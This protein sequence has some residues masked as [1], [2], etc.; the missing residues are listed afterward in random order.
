MSFG[1]YMVG[2][3]VLIVGL[4]IGAYMLHVPARWCG[5]Y[6]HDGT[7]NS[8]RRH[9]HSSPRSTGLGVI[10]EAKVPQSESAGFGSAHCDQ[11]SRIGCNASIPDFSCCK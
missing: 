10:P 3:I 11:A 6:L 8:D 7:W 9:H 1:M 2:Y 5:R 4:A